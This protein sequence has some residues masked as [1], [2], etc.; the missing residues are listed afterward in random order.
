MHNAAYYRRSLI[1]I[2]S[3][4]KIGGWLRVSDAI[5]APGM[6]FIRRLTLAQ[7][8]FVS[9]MLKISNWD[10]ALYLSAHE[11]PV[12]WMNPV[13]AAYIGAAIEVICPVLL[14]LGLM[15]R[16]AALPLLILTAVAQTAYQPIN[17]QVFWIVILG[18][19][20]VMG[21]NKDQWI[22]YCVD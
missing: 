5:L 2:D 20:I 21:A 18:Y 17:A 6:D 1:I 8:F 7:A 19:W 10:N 22:T 14:V 16:L 9:G 4:R 3:L 13:T 12:S 15:T 11:Y